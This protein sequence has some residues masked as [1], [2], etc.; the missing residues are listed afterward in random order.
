MNIL[1]RLLNRGERTERKVELYETPE[2]HHISLV[3][4]W[5]E[6]DEIGKPELARYACTA[7]GGTF[8]FE[9]T[10]GFVRHSMPPEEVVGRV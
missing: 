5:A 2:C 7:C 9:Q 1:N 3:P 4:H 10:R 6:A 8:D